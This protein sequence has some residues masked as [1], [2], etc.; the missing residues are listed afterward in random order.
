MLTCK[1]TEKMVMPY[2]KGELNEDE[3]EAFMQHL[4]GCSSCKEELEIYYTVSVGL[5]Q[6]DNGT[7]AYDIRKNLE[8]SL[9]LAWLRIKTTKLRKII[10][11][12]VNTLFVVWLSVSLILQFRM[13]IR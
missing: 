12:S 13:W 8:D 2:I 3:L 7:G 4:T 5:N 6:L 1:E 9:E 10:M 11:Y